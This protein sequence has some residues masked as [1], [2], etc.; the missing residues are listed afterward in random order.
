MVSRPLLTLAENSHII[1][2]VAV[3]QRGAAVI[4]E[5]TAVR[6]SVLPGDRTLR[7]CY[8]HKYS[9][10]SVLTDSPA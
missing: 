5:K 8:M 9:T 3:A 7:K 1:F 10:I 6:Y 2:Q 4:Y